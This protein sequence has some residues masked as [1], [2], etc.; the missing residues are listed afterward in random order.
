MMKIKTVLPVLCFVLILYFPFLSFAQIPHAGYTL[1]EADSSGNT[2]WQIAGTEADTSSWAPSFNVMS[3]YWWAADTT[4]ADSV[5]L[6]L[7]FQTTNTGKDIAITDRTLSI[8]TDSSSGVWK[9][10]M[11]AIG[12]G[13][14]YRVIVTGG[15]DNDKS[16]GSLIKMYF[17]GT[18]TR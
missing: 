8:A 10:T 15:G 14:Y 11:T 7:T 3:I 18:P 13:Q 16:V 9:L 2:Y 1:Q 4:G 6:T 12:S 5:D 17:D